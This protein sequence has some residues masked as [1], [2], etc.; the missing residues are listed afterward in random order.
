MTPLT[1]EMIIQSLNKSWKFLGTELKCFSIM[2]LVMAIVFFIKYK[3]EQNSERKKGIII[4]FVIIMILVGIPVG[5][6]FLE[7]SAIKNSITNN[8][9]EVV[10]DT[11]ERKR[12]KD[13]DNGGTIYYI[14]LTKNGKITV[15]RDTYNECAQGKSVY[16][17]IARGMLG[18][19]YPTSQIYS[20][21][22]YQY[23]NNEQIEK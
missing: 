10:T 7:Y 12:D 19:K 3:R 8:N 13:K 21:L 18:G 9:F 11:V 4:C 22:R 15:N 17:V 20:T 1:N 5:K 23:I 2:L 14:Y 6:G 16:V